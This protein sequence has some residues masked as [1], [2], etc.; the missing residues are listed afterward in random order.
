MG[1]F[2]K[3]STANVI[4]ELRKLVAPLPALPQPAALFS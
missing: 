4:S 2:F 1:D 3:R